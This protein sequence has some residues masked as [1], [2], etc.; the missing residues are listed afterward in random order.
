MKKI[1]WL[2]LV[3]LLV[4][5]CNDDDDSPS[6]TPPHEKFVKNIYDAENEPFI[7]LTYYPD[8][9][10]QSYNMGNF[11]L[12]HFT[13]E[14]DRIKELFVTADNTNYEFQYD[15]AGIITSFSNA[16]EVIPV[17]YNP[18]EKKYYVEYPDLNKLTMYLNEAG[19][20]KKLIYYDAYE[21][22][23]ETVNFIY[24]IGKKGGLTNTN[25]INIH[26]VLATGEPIL[27]FYSTFLT[28]VPLTSFSMS[29]GTII[30]ENEYD[31]DGF[32]TQSD[33]FI[34]GQPPLELRYEYTQL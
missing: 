33:I 1:I 13:Y 3:C 14:I 6:G 31:S 19:E 21:D 18:A 9:K 5:N 20:I 4:V 25:N 2:I 10:I 26:M 17:Q 11:F 34:N 24:D 7:K 28:N 30:Y 23:T 16:N 15:N 29:D 27:A 22:E 12:I 32:L 8:K